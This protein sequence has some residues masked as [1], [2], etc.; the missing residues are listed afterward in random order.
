VP[1][2]DADTVDDLIERLEQYGALRLVPAVKDPRRGP[3]ALGGQSR[4][5]AEIA[6]IVV[7][8]YSRWPLGRGRLGAEGK[9]WG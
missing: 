4:A 6:V 8:P 9:S 1:S 3:A 5:L 2:V 7:M